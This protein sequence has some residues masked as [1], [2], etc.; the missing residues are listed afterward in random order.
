MLLDVIVTG[1]LQRDALRIKE[2]AERLKEDAERMSRGAEL[3]E[4]LALEK[5]CL[6]NIPNM[7]R[8]HDTRPLN[9]RS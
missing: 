8:I 7:R 9:V 1:S 5:V 3:K 4:K 2:E 6:P